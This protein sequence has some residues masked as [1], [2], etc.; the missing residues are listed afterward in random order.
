MREIMSIAVHFET[1]ACE[2]IDF[3]HLTDVW[4]Y[5]LEDQFGK[6][7]LSVLTVDNLANFDEHDCD[8]IAARLRL[9]IIRRQ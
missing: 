8:R 3:T 6:E 7:C 1:W 4:P 5:L 2:H 9:T